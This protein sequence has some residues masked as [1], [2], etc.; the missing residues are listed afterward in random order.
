VQSRHDDAVRALQV[1]QEKVQRLGPLSP[2]ADLQARKTAVETT[3]RSLQQLAY[4]QQ[5]QAAE[6]G[7]RLA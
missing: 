7:A 3:H 1:A 2:L 6:W 4:A 5:V